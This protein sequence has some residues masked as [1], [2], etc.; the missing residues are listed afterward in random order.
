MRKCFLLLFLAS[1]LF[2]FSCTN[3][4][5]PDAPRILVFSKTMGFHHAS[6]PK[7]IDAIIKLG[8]ENGFD[9]DTTTNSDY[10]NNDSLKKYSAV[11]FLNT[12]GHVLNYI[13]R[14]AFERYIQAGG[15]FVGVHS[16]TDTEYDWGWYGRLVGAYF[17][18]HPN[19][20][21]AK[22]IIKDKDFPATKF[23]KDTI[24]TRTDELYNFKKI[25][26]DIHVLITIDESSYKGGTNGAFHPMSW[27]H[28]YDGGRAFYTEMG[29]TDESYSEPLYLKHLLGGIEYAIGDN[30]VLDYS[31]ATTQMPP[32]E[33]RFTKTS[34]VKGVFFE[35]TEMT[36]LPN[37]DILVLQRRGEIL[38]YDHTTREV[39]QVGFLN[40]YWKTE[41]TPGVNS[42]E[43]LLGIS[44]DPHFDKNHWVYIYYS[45]KDTSVN[46]LSRF[47]FENDTID[48]KS[49][50][51]ILQFYEQREICCHTGGS[52]AF[53][54]KGFLFVSTGDNST[55][56][57][58][59]GA[60][61]VSHGFAPL[62]DIPGHQQ[63][64]SRR[65]AGNSNDLRGKII[66]IKVNDDGTYDIPDGNLFPKGEANT[67]P[68]IYVMGDRNPYRISVDQK[69]GFLYWG[70]V[71]PDANNDSMET[72][73]SRG[74]DE[75]NQA[76]KAGFFGWP[77][78]VGDNYP[79]RQYDYATGKSGSLF[80]PAH[81]VNDSRN[82][83][84]IKDLPPAQPAFIWYPYAAS[85]D[86]PEL[87]SGGRCA[88]AG[89]VYYT[90]MFPEKTRLPD[91]Y[92]GKLFIYDWIRG[93]IMA[94]TMLPNGDF[95]K[96]EPFIEHTQLHNCSDMEVGPDGKLYLL[97][98]GTGWFQRNADAGLS[99]IDYNSGNRAP[100]IKAI[101]VDKTSGLLPLHIKATVEAKD[102]DKDAL[103][104]TWNV[105]NQKKTTTSPELDYTFNTA[106]DYNISVEVKDDKGASAKSDSI[107]VYAGNST[108]VVNIE[109]TGG[110]KSFYLPGIPVK[111]SVSIKD[112]NTSGVDLKNLF[113]AYDYKKDFVPVTN[114]EG[115][116]EA[117][118]PN[119]GGKILTQ[120][121]DC[122]NCHKENEKSVG[123]AFMLVSKKYANN[124]KAHDYL[125]Q[126]IRSGG[127]GVWGQVAMAAHPDI[128]QK[129]L[130]Q[131]ISWIFS[132][133]D[134][135]S[136]NKSLPQEGSIVPPA[137]EQPNAS[138]VLTA[139]Y[140]NNPGNNLKP[141]TGNAFVSLPGNYYFFSGNEKMEGFS[142]NGSGGKKF[143]E[144]PNEEG[145]FMIGH[146]D[147]T[148]VR[149][150]NILINSPA[151]VKNDYPFEIKIDSPDGKVIGKGSVAKLED[152]SSVVHITIDTVTDGNF[153]DIY[154][155]YKPINPDEKIQARVMAVQFNAK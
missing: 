65:S 154:F 105:G 126:K 9:V 57:D 108:P 6:I 63:Y 39:K 116:Q 22:F 25:N 29:H 98:Y 121:L 138:L 75:I 37:L 102:P 112:N 114:P 72:R 81:P 71:G 95:D 133:S 15:G 35:P 33:D 70:E 106:G 58:E 115:H 50:K 103:S 94:V 119:I 88:M 42:E 8:K 90:G 146:I 46:R 34:L 61:Y 31:K 14:A 59:P 85:T 38:K 99:C 141:L 24:W 87:G 73:G 150:V 83:T 123:P 132:L 11:I 151:S 134:K 62:N 101:H 129:D 93:W 17:N 64:D 49:E 43:G 5:R 84:G 68:E 79:Y 12:T 140:T 130:D 74:Y 137:K 122:K 60:K 80:D 86:F 76:R 128:S 2:Q 7:G 16:A 78:F 40:V 28:N 100:E 13:Q 120:T 142:V 149:S 1:S 113:I 111:Y 92:N 53:G 69:T 155:I 148:D 48:V 82:N 144:V 118:L 66:R 56:F 23:F 147:L 109:L 41:H 153:H 107:N 96:M 45:P 104:Y 3:N 44:K 4:K 54:P 131:I 125:S 97:E 67:R 77:L 20:Q 145:W 18:G 26:P 27:Y 55:P 21:E 47:T 91:Y 19:P 124:P 136:R 139:A 110:N 89:P 32:D 52:V 152:K 127:A 36:I 51:I 117:V 135:N 30:N 10:F 143:L